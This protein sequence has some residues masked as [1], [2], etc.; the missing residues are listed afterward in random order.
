METAFI[1]GI[2]GQDGSFLAELLLSKGYRVVGLVR[3]STNFSYPNLESIAGKVELVYG[4]LLDSS[5]L[6]GIIQ[7]YQPNE[8]YNLAAQSVPADSWKQPIVTGE[9]TALGPLRLLEAVRQFKPDARFYQ[10]TSREI[11]G[12]IPHEVT[13]ESMPLLAN[14]PRRSATSYA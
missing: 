13:Y 9:I 7:K 5:T 2:T 11:Y 10:A 14:N 1:T 3:R 12:A 4:D 8:V 6:G